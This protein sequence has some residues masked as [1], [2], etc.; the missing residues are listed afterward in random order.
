MSVRTPT[1]P[2][3]EQNY[4]EALSF[5]GLR[6]PRPDP[7]P[8]CPNPAPARPNPALACP[9][10]A[11]ACPNPVLDRPVSEILPFPGLPPARIGPWIRRPLPAIL[12]AGPCPTPDD[13]RAP[14][15]CTVN[16]ITKNKTKH[17]L[18]NSTLASFIAVEK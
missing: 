1:T 3:S 5:S 17:K 11:P 10:P 2:Y 18:H 14:V 4:A 9:N 15:S 13:G 8:A 12:R 16:T 7:A 6:P